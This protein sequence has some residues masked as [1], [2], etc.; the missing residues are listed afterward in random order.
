MILVDD[1]H[2]FSILL[3]LLCGRS[4]EAVLRS[5]VEVFILSPG[6]WAHIGFLVSTTCAGASSHFSTISLYG[7][8]IVWTKEKL[9]NSDTSTRSTMITLSLFRSRQ[10]SM[11]IIANGGIVFCFLVPLLLLEWFRCF[12]LTY[13]DEDFSFH[14]ERDNI[15][16]STLSCR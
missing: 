14:V 16:Y 13:D 4:R 6:T 7:K 5:A 8:V 12:A 15:L 11:F 2:R 1:I 9:C 3:V 10:I